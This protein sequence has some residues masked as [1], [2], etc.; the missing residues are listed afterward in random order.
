MIERLPLPV[1]PANAVA[2]A[3]RDYLLM[4]WQPIPIPL[5]AKNP[6]RDDWQLER[7]TVEDVPQ[8]FSSQGNIGVLTGEAEPWPD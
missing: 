6:G 3:A 4:G 8:K 7:W 1:E 2:Q 5:R